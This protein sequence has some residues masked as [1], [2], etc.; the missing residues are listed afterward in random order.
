MVVMDIGVGGA[1][2]M[3]RE[4]MRESSHAVASLMRPMQPTAE[5]RLLLIAQE[6]NGR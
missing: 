3:G 4:Q 1:Q 5:D 2:L 6:A